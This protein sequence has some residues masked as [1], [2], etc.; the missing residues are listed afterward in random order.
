MQGCG[1]QTHTD[2]P[3]WRT[4]RERGDMGRSHWKKRALPIA[5]A[6]L[7]M[8]VACSGAKVR[9]ADDAAG[10]AYFESKI[11]PVL[12]E[13]CYECHSSGAKKLR[14]GLRLDT[15]D[16][17]RAGG[18][19][20][21]AVVPGN[22][23][24]S[25]VFQAISGAQGV[26]RMPPKGVL[27]AGVIA[28]FREWIK[29]GAP[30][31]RDR[32]AGG[33]AA[34]QTDWWSLKPLLRPTVPRVGVVKTGWPSNPID[35]FILAKLTE[36]G[37]APSPVADRRTLIRR[38]SF[39]LL[40]LPPEPEE[41]DAFESDRSADAYERLVERL[42]SSPHYGERSARYWMDLVHF[43]ETHGHDQDRIRP[44]AW[45]Y[46]DYLIHSFNRD[47][48]YG[49]FVAEQVAADALFP[50]EPELVVALGMLAAGP[51]DEGSLRDIRDDS[52]DRQIG[53]YMDRDDMVSTVMSTFVS[54]TA[55]CARCHDH[56]FDPISQDDYYSLQAVF[57]GVDKAERPYDTDAAVS[58]L[59]RS[60][61]EQLEA[62]KKSNADGAGWISAMLGALPPQRL[63]FAGASEFAPDAGHRP[64]GGPR[65]V[66]V[67]RR[68][69][70]HF[71]VKPASPGTLG[72]LKELPSRFTVPQ[73]AD[74]SARRAC[75]ARWII[76]P[77]NSLSWRSIV[78]RAW[79]H[80]FGRGLVATPNDFGRMGAIPSHPELLDWLATTFRD[81]GGSLKGLDRLIVTSATY[82]QSAASEASFAAADADNQWLWRQNRRRLD[83]ESTHDAILKLAGRLDTAMGGPSVQ[84]FTLS[85]GVHVTPVVDYTKYDWNS[86]GSCRRGVSVCVQNAA[87]PVLRCA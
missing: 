13:R 40:G 70:I 79:Q 82:R 44:N 49:R 83:A 30:D 1:V 43:A 57:A 32:K 19:S 46:R 23:D 66:S 45:P 5:G 59:R 16:G 85:P 42:L 69:D 86:V 71:P 36:K 67:L 9:A 87:G 61:G 34:G 10:L 73:G 51:W 58:R 4:L 76:D 39:D 74:E 64:P 56:K 72:C 54:S 11:R 68:G 84:Q 55:G 20:G 6:I 18:D 48:P 63:V 26:D 28:D 47:K 31:P 15:R 7:V 41:V 33:L 50:D 8:I 24:E 80:H 62:A 38:L 14:G 60:L 65:A 78:N 29:M 2:G 21:P 12:V 37:L 22:L 25:L 75:L 53:H 77:R 35:A 81:S 3:Q 17:I 52:I 27:P